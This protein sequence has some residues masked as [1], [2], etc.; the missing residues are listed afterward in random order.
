M[1][2]FKQTRKFKNVRI[3]TAGRNFKQVP[4]NRKQSVRC[5]CFTFIFDKM[6]SEISQG[7]HIVLTLFN[8]FINDILYLAAHCKNDVIN[9]H[10]DIEH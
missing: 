2:S 7:S 9:S 5:C 4:T 8:I 3:I 10:D 6:T 1:N